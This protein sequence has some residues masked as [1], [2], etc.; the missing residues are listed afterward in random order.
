MSVEITPWLRYL[1]TFLIVCHGY[2]YIPLGTF[3][4]DIDKQKEW[5]DHSWLFGKNAT[6]DRLKSF[7][8]ITHILTGIVIVSGGI[9][10]GFSYSRME[11]W[12]TLLIVGSIA[13]IVVFTIF[14]DGQVRFIFREGGLG[15]FINLLILVFVWIKS[16]L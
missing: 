8:R 14:W 3:M 7:I 12:R 13:G 11:L 9:V 6:Q 10:F 5:R 1:I 16:S 15:V 4:L 2:V